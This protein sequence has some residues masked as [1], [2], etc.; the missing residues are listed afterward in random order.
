MREGGVSLTPQENESH[1]ILRPASFRGKSRVNRCVWVALA[2]CLLPGFAEAQ[3]LRIP[4]IAEPPELADFL[5]MTPSPA[6]AERFAS[7]TGFVQRT[8]QDGIAAR[9][10]TDVYV[11]YDDRNFYAVFVAFDD[12]PW[13]VRANFAPREN[14]DDDDTVGVLIDTFNDRLTGYGFHSS[15]LGVQWDARWSEVGGGGYDES[16]EAV[17]RTDAER[18]DSGYVVLMTIPFRAMRFPESSEQTWRIQFERVIPR[19]SEESHWPPYSQTIDGR[20]NQA[21]TLVGVRNVSPG[22]NIQLIPFAFMRSY[23][24]LDPALPGGPGFRD[25]TEDDVGLDAKFVLRDSLVLD[26]TYNPD[27]SQIESDEPQVT[28]NQRFEVQF[29]ERRPFFLEN[30][31]FF[32]TE[33]PLVFTRRI[34]DPEHGLKFTGR[35]GP[36]GFGTMLIDD[37]APGAAMPATDPLYREAA[38]IG[39]LRVFRDVGQQ[40]RAGALFTERELGGAYNRVAAA[41]S[42]VRLSDNWSTQLLLVNTDTRTAAGDTFSGRQTNWR[43]DRSGRH[44]LVHAHWTQQ[45]DGFDAQLGILGRNYQPGTKGLHGNVEYRFWPEGT[46]IDRIGPRIFHAHQEDLD[47]QRVY[48]ELSPAMTM[49]WAGDSNL[50]IGTNRIRERLRPRDF[51]GLLATR[52]YSQERWYVEFGTNVFSKAGFFAYYDMGS[53]INFVPPIGAQ[54]DLADRTYI[55]TQVDLRPTDRLRVDTTYIYTRLDER[56]GGAEIFENRILRNRWNYQFTKEMSLRFIA[57]LEETEPSARTSLE[58]GRNVNYDV[59]FRYVLNP[60]SAL[61][62]GYNTNQS[63]FQVVDLN[64]P[65]GSGAMSEIVRT[66]DLARDGKQLFV[67]FSY[68]LQP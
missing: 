14:I 61:Y 29:P 21:A 51:P 12:E 5:S 13:N 15:P 39:V 6:V 7:V 1:V 59:L 9:Q 55:H 62:V 42:H 48:A 66:N 20:L 34:V 47:G 52:D 50:S 64:E 53:V 19:F 32:R 40:S 26:L 24:V 35:Q 8:P 27:F 17:W 4:R 10:R 41:D 16:F 36:W 58:R 3:E 65:N 31:D 63:N 45:S 68:L 28:V 22:R 46:W 44:A 11:A 33:T 2:A 18:T 38:D 25:N 60:W 57:Q 49:E 30:T 54:P 56:A 43:F 37:E 67:K 23:D